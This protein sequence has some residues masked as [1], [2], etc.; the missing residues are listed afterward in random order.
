MIADLTFIIGLSFIL[1][2]IMLFVSSW[3]W[4]Y[5]LFFP[6]AFLLYICFVMAL[7]AIKL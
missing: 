5:L 4:Y 6:V 3:R 1:A 2:A 7:M